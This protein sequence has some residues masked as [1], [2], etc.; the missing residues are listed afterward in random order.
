MIDLSG[1]GTGALLVLAARHHWIVVPEANS[2]ASSSPGK[3]SRSLKRKLYCPAHPDQ[4]LAGG[5]RRYFLH[6]L[7]A[8]ELS[9]RGMPAAKA[10][11]LISAYPVYTLSHEWLEEL[12]CLK[13]G[14]AS[15]CHVV[16]H[17]RVEHTVRWAPR[18]LWEHVAHVDPLRANPSISDFSRREARRA[19]S[20]RRYWEP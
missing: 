5:G 9:Q 17:N 7:R 4:L 12:F 8:E 3:L 1:C 11:L 2:S 15:W 13:C 20:N 6:L 19:N 14:M 10:K 18:E 16:R